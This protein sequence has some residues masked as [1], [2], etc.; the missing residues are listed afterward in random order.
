MTQLRKF[1]LFVITCFL[2]FTQIS[3]KKEKLFMNDATLIGYDVRAC[4]CCGGLEIV[5]KDVPNPNGNEYFL[6]GKLPS[7]FSVGP[8]PK[9]PIPV[10]ID[11]AVDSTR[12]FGNY[13]DITRI[14]RQ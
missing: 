9:F 8:D 3:C 13:I 7:D 11:W 6:I 1:V 4:V 2:I 5:I 12:C 14:A 10:K